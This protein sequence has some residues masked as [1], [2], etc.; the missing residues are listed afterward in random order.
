[1]HLLQTKSIR[2]KL[3]GHRGYLAL[4]YLWFQSVFPRS[5]L[6][7][8]RVE[9]LIKKPRRSRTNDTSSE[10]RKERGDIGQQARRH[11]LRRRAWPRRLQRP[12]RLGAVVRG[13]EM[14]YL[15]AVNCGADPE[16]IFIKKLQKNV[17]VKFFHERN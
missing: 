4:A 16:S 12:V 13:T 14:C 8:G 1:M 7:F 5:N 2:E 3:K 17:Y 15:G 9:V 10:R 11:K 6:S